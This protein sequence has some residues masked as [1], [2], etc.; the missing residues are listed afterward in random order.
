VCR[1]GETNM[2]TANKKL[3]NSDYATKSGHVSLE[4]IKGFLRLSVTLNHTDEGLKS[5]I[6]GFV[7]TKE[8]EALRTE[9]ELMRS[10]ARTYAGIVPPK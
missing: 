1:Q 3:A 8:S 5:S 6:I 2:K 10:K 7:E 9:V 4:R